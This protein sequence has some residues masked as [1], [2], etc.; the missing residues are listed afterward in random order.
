MRSRGRGQLRHRDEGTVLRGRGPGG[1]L[2]KA[3]ETAPEER[4]PPARIHAAF[5]PPGPAPSRDQPREA[6]ATALV[7]LGSRYG[8][9]VVA[10]VLV[11]CEASE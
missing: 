9:S 2:S 7:R 6:L 11:M 8:A 10:K 5:T 4:Q 3:Q 1:G